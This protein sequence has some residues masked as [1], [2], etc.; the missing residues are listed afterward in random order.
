MMT[1]VGVYIQKSLHCQMHFQFEDVVVFVVIISTGDGGYQA[2]VE[3]RLLLVEMA[4]E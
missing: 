2:N 4:N 3:T 1:V